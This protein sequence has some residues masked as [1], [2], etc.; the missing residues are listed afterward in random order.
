MTRGATRASPTH[1]LVPLLLAVGCGG[2][3]RDDNEGSTTTDAV[4]NA[5]DC[6]DHDPTIYPGAGELCDGLD[7]DCDGQIDENPVDVVAWFPDRD[8]DGW[9]DEAAG[10]VACEG[11]P[12]DITRGGDCEDTDATVHPFAVEICGDG[13]DNDCLGG[14]APC[15]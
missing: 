13:I 2:T 6:N 4:V 12:G 7:N 11:T 5:D 3:A 1:W 10:Q 9:G 14:D 15:G 8:D